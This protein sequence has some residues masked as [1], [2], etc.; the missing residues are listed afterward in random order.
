M[1]STRS[2]G[3]LDGWINASK[4]ADGTVSDAEFKCLHGVTSSI[5]TQLNSKSASSHVHAAS[6]ITSGTLGVDRGGT[7]AVN[8]T[9]GNILR[10]AGTGP[11]TATLAAPAGALVG[12]TDSQVLTNKSLT[13]NSNNVIARE[14]WVGNGATS[15]SSYAATAPVAGQVLTAT[16]STLATWQTPTAI[17][18]HTGL[19]NIGTNTH[20]Q[21]DSHIASVANPHS[22]TKAQVG[23]S[24]VANLK[25]NLAATT[26]PG[27][28]SDSASGYSIGSRWFDTVADKEYVCLDAG[29]GVAIWKETTGGVVGPI[30]I[31]DGGTG[32]T[33]KAAGFDALAPTTTKG[34]L[35]V[36]NGTNNIRLPAGTNGQVL[37]LDS[38]E[39]CGLKWM[40][41]TGVPA[42]SS[43]QFQYNNG[44]IFGATTRLIIDADYPCLADTL[45]STPA[46]PPNGAKLFAK[47]R[48]GRRMTG[49][50]GPSGIDYTFQPS[51]FSGKIAWWTSMGNGSSISTINFGNTTTGTTT[52]RN[53]ATTNLFT[54]MRR[55]GFVSTTTA[56]TSAGT[57]HGAQQFFL[58]NVDGIGGFFYVARFGI[59]SSATVANQ[60]T[61]V[62][63]IGQTT[64]LTNADPSTATNILGFGAD[65][66]DVSFSFMHNNQAG[67]AVKESLTGTFP[68]RDLSTTMYEARIFVAPNST[69]VYYSLEALNSG[70]LFEG[71]VDTD[72]P[73][74]GTLLSPQIWTNNG[75]TSLAAGIDVVSQYI[76]TDN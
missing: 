11:V 39:L 73:A 25:V 52:T 5:Q 76:E 10:G 64:V 21:I 4:I 75:S 14:I 57:R 56:G 55:V 16:S 74:V 72:I 23:L 65:S 60:R 47:F 8:F 70:S 40:T 32:Q 49:Q 13:A 29:V 59:S 54:S 9:S 71:F 30:S 26:A 44:G 34:D 19:T 28:N 7:G 17:T 61:F 3:A 36:H 53:V 62:G 48:A 50:V 1:T 63:L 67:P 58:S 33:S 66:A 35:I 69:T 46:P 2:V 20:A 27:A 43:G 31:A 38:A 12:T 37:G 24:D 15:V 22:V 51:L 41:G 68:A 18:S 45:G 6:D 42:G